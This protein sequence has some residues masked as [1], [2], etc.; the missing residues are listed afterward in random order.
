MEYLA[1]SNESADCVK[2]IFKTQISG[3]SDSLRK[4]TNTH[5][6]TDFIQFKVPSSK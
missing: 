6:W 5:D 1:Q 3:Q 4:N 2:K